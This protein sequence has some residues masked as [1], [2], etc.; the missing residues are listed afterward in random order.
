MLFRAVLPHL[1]LPSPLH[2]LA[3]LP[4]LHGNK[5]DLNGHLYGEMFLGYEILYGRVSLDDELHA[6]GVASLATKLLHSGWAPSQASAIGSALYGGLCCSMLYV[7]TINLGCYMFYGTQHKIGFCG[8]A[9]VDMPCCN[10]RFE[11]LQH[12]F[13]DVAIVDLRCSNMFFWMLQLSI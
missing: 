7:A 9:T 6:R 12:V 8:V 11:M 13:L 10:S 2:P 4:C 1:V 3:F 5:V